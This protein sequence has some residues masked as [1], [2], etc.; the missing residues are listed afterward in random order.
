M[1]IIGLLTLGLVAGFA[2]AFLG[3]GGGVVLVP[4]LA[5]FFDYD[6]KKAIGTSLATIVPAALVG[7]TINYFIKSDNIQFVAALF[8]ILGSIAGAKFGA[9][10]AAKISGRLLTL[11]FAVLLLFVGLKQTGVVNIPTEQIT[12]IEIYPLLIILGLAAGVSSALFG[13]GGGVVVVPA[14]SLFFGFSMHQAIATSLT[15]IV[16][17]AFAGAV[18]H[19]K[20]NNINTGAIK[21]LIPASLIGAV[22]GAIIS[23]RLSSDALQFIFG[24]LLIFCSFKLGLKRDRL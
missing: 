23:N 2:S 14:L 19:S 22:L 20:F 11:L 10:I 12:N 9:A 15:V 8:I 24:I 6:I 18:F 17:T 21:Y 16:P 4:S 7:V 1:E 5:L 13:I 3:I